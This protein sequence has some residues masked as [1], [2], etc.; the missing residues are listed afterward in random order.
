MELNEKY[1]SY[2]DRLREVEGKD[3]PV[4]LLRPF[5]IA[6]E[7]IYDRLRTKLSPADFK[8]LFLIMAGLLLA[9]GALHIIFQQNYISILFFVLMAAYW[10]YYRM[11][12]KKVIETQKQLNARIRQRETPE[13]NFTALLIDRI[14][15]I[16]N[17]LDVLYKRIKL[18]RNQ[19]I[20]F[21]PV[22][23]MLFIH[24][25]RGSMS[26]I[27]WI[28]SILVSVIIGGVF[29]VYY[30]NYEMMELDKITDELE[31]QSNSLKQHV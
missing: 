2:Q 6:V 26:T 3:S 14:D 20:A 10:I 9:M 11:E 8:W 29:W 13:T 12:M 23:L 25:V 21:F 31:E 18:V 22:I 17:G 15:Y 16:K 27:L 30:F 7:N 5:H 1:K 24:T 19:Y 4:E 28:S